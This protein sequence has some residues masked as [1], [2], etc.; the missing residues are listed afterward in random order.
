MPPKKQRLSSRSSR[1]Q[2]DQNAER[3]RQAR[4]AEDSE[5][6]GHQK[7]PVGSL[8]RGIGSDIGRHIYGCVDRGVCGCA[9]PHTE[10]QIKMSDPP[11]EIS[12]KASKQ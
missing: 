9:H 11:A 3:M 7:N 8:D 12:K 4:T 5:V 2:R 6:A 10:N 1:K